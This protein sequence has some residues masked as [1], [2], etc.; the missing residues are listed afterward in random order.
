MR[1][2]KL[3]ARCGEQPLL[4]QPLVVSLGPGLPRHRDALLT[5]ATNSHLRQVLDALL[6]LISRLLLDL[7]T[8]LILKCR[9]VKS[10]LPS[11]SQFLAQ[12][13]ELLLLLGNLLAVL[14]RHLGLVLHHF[15]LCVEGLGDHL[16]FPVLLPQRVAP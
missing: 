4:A 16:I 11:T 3:R 7:A 9:A 14:R 8:A 15:L 1:L 6:L 2:G 13:D 5:E 10:S 12:L